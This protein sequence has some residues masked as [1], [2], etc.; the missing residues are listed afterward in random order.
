MDYQLYEYV[1]S[2]GE[3]TLIDYGLCW[4]N[5]E[6][7]SVKD[8]AERG[9]FAEANGYSFHYEPCHVDCATG[10]FDA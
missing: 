6:G 5:H 9:E 3:G 1:I 7:V 8:I 2:A 4:D 10:Q